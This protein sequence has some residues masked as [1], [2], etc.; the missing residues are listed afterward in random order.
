M[1]NVYRWAA[2]GTTLSNL[3][4]P[5]RMEYVNRCMLNSK[6]RV[7]CG[8]SR[9]LTDSDYAR[10]KKVCTSLLNYE[11]TPLL[12]LPLLAS[13]L[14]IRRLAVKDESARMGMNSFKI[15]GVSY[16]IHRLLEDGLL[17][18]NAVLAAATDGNHGL[19]VSQVARAHGW[20]ARIYVHGQTTPGRIAAL[21]ER[22]A[23]VTVV[24]GNYDDAVDQAKLDAVPNGWTIV[25]D[26]SWPGYTNIP[27][28]IMAGYTMLIE[29]AFQEWS[30]PRPPDI[31]LIQVGVGG[32]LGAVVS[33]LCDKYGL[34]RPFVI[35]CEPTSA[36]CLLE[37]ARAGAAVSLR[38]TLDTIM[39][40][41]SCGRVS[42][43]VW[44]M[45]ANTVDAFVAIDDEYAKV[46]MKMLARPTGADPRI[47]AGESGA[48][49][50]GALLAILMDGSLSSVR[51]ASGL[52]S[53]SS[54]LLVNTE[55]ATDPANYLPHRRRLGLV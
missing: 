11:P 26:T 2:Y 44:P 41:L 31:I 10:V 18:E 12:D 37:S 20:S 28:D 22:G 46:A 27:R 7:P 52:S 39:A 42:H 33:W 40:G 36:A 1:S 48:C 32:L 21:R 38:G 24:S 34:E 53:E 50:L 49:G 5:A 23:H 17:S 29:E 14:N 30:E 45:L 19:A 15:L 51:R 6:A 35:A 16:A 43:V 4:E 8:D 25:S 13:Q 55:G 3:S 47:V 9:L 54:V